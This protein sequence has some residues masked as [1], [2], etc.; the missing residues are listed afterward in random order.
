MKKDIFLSTKKKIIATSTIIVFGCLIVFAIITQVL[1]SS[2][3]LDVID[4]QLLEQKEILAKEQF[5]PNYYE[6]IFNE[7]RHNLDGDLHKDEF[8]NPS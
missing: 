1:Y 2:R 5:N 3:V 8:K 6:Y 7:D 4:H